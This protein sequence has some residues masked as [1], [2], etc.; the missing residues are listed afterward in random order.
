MFTAYA[1]RGFI[2]ILA[3]PPPESSANRKG[4][5]AKRQGEAPFPRLP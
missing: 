3:R 5:G 2:R 1:A 4:E